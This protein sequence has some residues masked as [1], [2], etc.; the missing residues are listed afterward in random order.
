MPMSVDGFLFDSGKILFRQHGV[1]F[2]PHTIPG[3]VSVTV[4]SHGHG[5]RLGFTNGS[6]MSIQWHDGAYCSNRFLPLNQ[7]YSFS[8]DAQISIFTSAGEWHN[9]GNATVAGWQSIQDVMNYIRH[10][11]N[12][13]AS[14]A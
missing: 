10:H 6:C 2:S 9:F 5:C 7:E 3:V 14:V 8:P 1:E 4:Y 12:P 11:A 13:F